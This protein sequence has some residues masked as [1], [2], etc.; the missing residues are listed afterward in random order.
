MNFLKYITRPEIENPSFLFLLTIKQHNI[1]TIATV[2]INIFVVP[3]FSNIFEKD[4]AM[5]I[6]YLHIIFK[7]INLL[8]SV[9]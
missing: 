4:F 9:N 2:I 5:Y 1:T 7:I 6:Y 8:N 3:S